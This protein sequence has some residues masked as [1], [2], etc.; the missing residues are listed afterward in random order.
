MIFLAAPTLGLVFAFL[1]AAAVEDPAAKAN[2][3]LA[4]E[5][6][7]V[8]VLDALDRNIAQTGLAHRKA[9]RKLTDLKTSMARLE[10]ELRDVRAR[11]VSQ[12]ALLTRRLRARA[13]LDETGITRVLLDAE[14][15]TDFIRRRNYVRRILAADLTL[16]RSLKS[17]RTLRSTLLRRQQELED[18]LT[19]IDA[20][21]RTQYTALRVERAARAEVLGTVRRER[22]LADRLLA[23]R[24][25][26]RRQLAERV[27][28]D[29]IFP[30]EGGRIMAEAGALPWPVSGQII[31]GYG[32][33]EDPELG[34]YTFHSGLAIDA[35]IGSSVRAVFAGRVVYSGW[36]K[37]FGN[38]VII[39]H[40]EGFHTLHAHLSAISKAR[41]EL[42]LQ[43]AV[44]GEVGDTGSLHGP[45]L[46]FELRRNGRPVDPGRWLRR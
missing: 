39:D 32:R 38:L 25:K 40:G 6:E 14:E 22:R 37:G 21:L 11:L 19:R 42:V 30:G 9:K 16:L 45:Q 46:Y 7:V 33:Q 13:Q 15:P 20:E 28:A 27:A 12:R 31:R 34:T 18:G 1:A 8:D 23:G 3:L 26:A 24:A 41:G 29:P 36:Y 44:V 17:D 2:R 35:K 4:E 43:G 5:H 10:V